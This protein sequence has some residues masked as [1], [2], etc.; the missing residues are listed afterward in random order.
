M[1]FNKI[2]TV[3]AVCL[4]TLSLTIIS[5]A[6]G[7][8]RTENAPGVSRAECFPLEK[9]SA[10]K[11]KAAEEL[12]LKA[13]DDAALFTFVGGLKPMSSGFKSMQVRSRLPQI[14]LADAENTVSGLEAKKAED[15]TAQE[16]GQLTQAKQV[17]D[18][19]KSL[20]N[21]D[22]TREMLAQ[23]RCGDDFYAGVQHFTRLYD[24]V[25]HLDS[26]VVYKPR[27]REQITNKAAFFSRWG[28]TVN[29]HPLDVLYAVDADETAARQGGYG[30]LFGY[31][32]Y[33][34]KFFVLASE[35]EEFSGEFVARDFTSI[36]TFGRPTNSFVY[37]VP[38]GHVANDADRALK[39]RAEPILA[40]YK[41]R[42][43]EYIG[44]GKKG[45]VELIRDWFCDGA[46]KCTS[47]NAK[48]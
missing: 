2:K 33:A 4:F 11:R 46:G 27:L 37:A 39:A 9:L 6:Q 32:D 22:D 45:I 34:V 26:F 28:I 8:S 15:L 3:V 10:E 31:P 18:R 19:A 40:E 48:Y 29:S 7:V 36:P 42:R 5:N 44:E 30:Y 1:K 41:K 35:E 25:R 17:V 38:K 47:S 14:A 16:K 23:W 13:M 20:K 21:I 12:L 43:A 24:G